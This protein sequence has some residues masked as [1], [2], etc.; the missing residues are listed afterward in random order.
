VESLKA[1]LRS[2]LNREL[3]DVRF[4]FEPADIISEVMSFGSPTPI[5]VAVSGPN[6]AE[7]R[8]FAQRMQRELAK[9]PSLRDLQVAQSLDYPTIKVDVD[10]Q[11][12]GLVGV[13]PA[14]V[15]R[16]IVPATSSSRFVTPNFWAD[17]ATGIGYQ[18]QVEVPRPVVRWLEGA[19]VGSIK[20]VELLPVKHNAAGEL[21]V[22]DVAAVSTGSMPGEYDRY[23]MRREISLTANVVGED[24]GTVAGRVTQAIAQ[25]GEPPRGAKVEVRGQVPPMREMLSGLGL[26]IGLAVMF[27]F[28]LL[29]AN[30]QSFRLAIVTLSTAPAVIVGVVLA[31]F[32]TRT[33]LNIQSLIGSIMAMGVAMANAILL[34]TFAENRRR[35]GEA[36]ADAAVSGAA[37]RLRAILMTSFAMMAGMLPMAIALG[38]S[39]Q[40]NAPLG[41]AVL[42]GLA[43]A[44][45]A[46]L[47][48]LPSAFALLQ[49]KAE[50]RPASFD[51]DDPDSSYFSRPTD[52]IASNAGGAAP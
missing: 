24:L 17:P 5:E 25:S 39:G 14:D 40:H 15:S 45:L 38:E 19:S 51:P 49:N 28:L 13:S 31:L 43:A 48:I 7:T 16:A 46:T 23:N 20:D 30:F 52:A 11:R 47:L 33:T 42:G 50:A 22:R 44:T 1:E 26:G 34:V 21:L 36:A 18:V 10:R 12:A 4:S 6:F 2:T 8:T 9:T 37:S 27:I 32:V 41:R 3:P 29:A 35:Q